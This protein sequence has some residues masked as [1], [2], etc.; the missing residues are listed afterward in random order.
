MDFNSSLFD[1]IRI[2]RAREEQQ[3][4]ERRCEHPGCQRPGNHRAPMGRHR[5]GRY[6]HFCLDHVRAYNQSYNYFAG[7]NDESIQ[8]FQK[9]AITGHR[10]TWSMGI[11]GSRGPDLEADDTISDILGLFRNGRRT[12]ERR[13]E[14]RAVSA[15]ASKALDALGLEEGAGRA[16]VRAQFKSLAK[17]FHP[18]LNGGDRSHEEKLRAIIDAYNYLK[19]A[20]LA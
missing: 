18:D 10:P 13:E 5:E 9:D 16:E 7:M 3:P 1:K 12:T 2:A 19:S 6:F 4:A 8:A 17:R 20:G 11:K 15:G 14:R